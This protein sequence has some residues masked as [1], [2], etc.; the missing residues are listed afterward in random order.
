MREIKKIPPFASL[1]IYPPVTCLMAVVGFLLKEFS[2]RRIKSKKP[3][4]DDL[5][6]VISMVGLKLNNLKEIFHVHLLTKD[7]LSVIPRPH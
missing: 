1:N 4:G 6:S 3:S 2:A 7:L 5:D